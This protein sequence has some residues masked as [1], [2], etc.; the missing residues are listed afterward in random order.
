MLKTSNLR[1]GF[2]RRLLPGLCPAKILS[3]GGPFGFSYPREWNK[4]F[5]LPMN[6]LRRR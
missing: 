2:D 3:A 1:P 6:G 5:L 4:H